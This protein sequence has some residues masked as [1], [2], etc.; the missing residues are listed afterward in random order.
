MRYP[1]A[2]A[3]AV[4]AAA[5]A[6]GVMAAGVYPL[7]EVA[8]CAAHRLPDTS[9]ATIGDDLESCVR[10][11][12][13]VRFWAVVIGAILAA[14]AVRLF[15]RRG[16]PQGMT[17]AVRVSGDR[18]F[19]R[20]VGAGVWGAIAA[21]LWAARQDAI[22]LSGRGHDYVTWAVLA[23]AAICALHVVGV[24]LALLRPAVAGG[25]TPPAS[26]QP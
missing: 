17:T 26:S 12:G 1:V 22:G 21:A 25:G 24:V 13:G 20:A 7:A 14:A 3:G 15:N 10:Q 5:A 23:L 18:A 16:T 2:V 19:S 9:E 11:L 4:V 6:A 8:V